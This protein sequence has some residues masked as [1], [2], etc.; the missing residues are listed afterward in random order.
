MVL[1]MSDSYSAEVRHSARELVPDRGGSE[2]GR[3]SRLVENAQNARSN[4]SIC[5]EHAAPDVNFGFRCP[6]AGAN[7]I[8]CGAF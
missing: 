8:A 1:L 5:S 2:L 4:S 6:K 7:F 3:L